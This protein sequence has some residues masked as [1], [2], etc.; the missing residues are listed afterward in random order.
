M[1]YN[2]TDVVSRDVD[3][4]HLVYEKLLGNDRFNVESCV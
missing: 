2:A 3:S 1:I 4:K